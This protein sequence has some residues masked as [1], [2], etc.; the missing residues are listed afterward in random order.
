VVSMDSFKDKNGSIDWKAY[1]EAQIEAGEK[2]YKC[3]SYI[4]PFDNPGH[5][6]LCWDCKH[7]SKD[8]ES[9]CHERMIRCPK[10]RNEMFVD[11]EENSH[12]FSVYDGEEGQ[13]NCDSCGYEFTVVV[14]ITY[15]FKSPELLKEAVLDE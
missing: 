6:Q 7:L 3:R 1:N 5:I 14:S 10:C 8:H 11:Y 13:V 12:L 15:S 4:G 2:C 9:V